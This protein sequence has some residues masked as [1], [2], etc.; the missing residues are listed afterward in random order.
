MPK[1]HPSS[2]EIREFE[3]IML[4]M[5]QSKLQEICCVCYISQIESRNIEE[6][7]ND[8]IDIRH[9]F[10]HNLVEDKVVSLEVV[11]LEVQI[12]DILTKPLDVS[13]FD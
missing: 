6:S 2:N 1:N 5:R 8:H 11:S 12:V 7:L 9:H 10:I 13:R 4:T 3:E